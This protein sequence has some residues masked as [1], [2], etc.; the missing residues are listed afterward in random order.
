MVLNTL[1]LSN[2]LIFM[3]LMEAQSP[4]EKLKL[5]CQQK[6][7]VGGGVR[8]FFRQNGHHYYERHTFTLVN[9]RLF[10]CFTISKII[11]NNSFIPTMLYMSITDAS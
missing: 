6:V 5:E 4:H 7:C 3:V 9:S 10:C 1:T 11:F 2:Q 8:G